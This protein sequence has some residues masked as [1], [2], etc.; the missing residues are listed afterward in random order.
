MANEMIFMVR[1][2]PSLKIVD[3]LPQRNQIYKSITRYFNELAQ[4][5]VHEVECWSQANKTGYYYKK[6]Q[7]SLS[8][9]VMEAEENGE[10]G[11]DIPYYELRKY[12]VTEGYLYGYYDAYQVVE[13]IKPIKYSS[14]KIK[15]WR[16]KIK[17]EMTEVKT[18]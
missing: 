6:I 10:L 5:P 2:E 8:D 17:E 1:T 4:E 13:V 15:N 11:D 12:T 7:K 16:E 3:A 18:F 14:L 9:L